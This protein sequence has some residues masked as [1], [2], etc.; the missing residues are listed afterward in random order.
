MEKK[1]GKVFSFLIKTLVSVLDHPPYFPDLVLKDSG[2]LLKANTPLNDK[3]LSPLSVFKKMCHRLG[4]QLLK[5]QSSKK[6]F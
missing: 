4:S 5:K 3:D 1:N 6:C 2:Y